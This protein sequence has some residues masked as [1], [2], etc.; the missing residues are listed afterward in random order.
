MLKYSLYHHN[1][2]ELFDE[3]LVSISKFILKFLFFFCDYGKTRVNYGRGFG[4]GTWCDD[5]DHYLSTQVQLG[6]LRQYP[7]LP[8]TLNV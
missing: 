8:L 5:G 7:L 1:N 2:E 4:C 6:K 3:I